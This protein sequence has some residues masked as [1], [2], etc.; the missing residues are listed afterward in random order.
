MPS[1]AADTTPVTSPAV[2][3]EPTTTIAPVLLS[4]AFR[5]RRPNWSP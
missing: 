2:I 5:L 1:S 4:S 3:A